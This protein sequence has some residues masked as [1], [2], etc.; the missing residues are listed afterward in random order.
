MD[1]L[2]VAAPLCNPPSDS[3]AVRGLLLTA[4]QLHLDVLAEVQPELKD[5]F[6]KQHREDGLFD[7]VQYLI[8]PAEREEAIRLDVRHQYCYT[9]VAR[10]IQFENVHQLIGQLVSLNKMLRGL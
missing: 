8:T 2:I 4:D 5:K 3:L 1:K 10:A 7:Y 9:V 6:Y